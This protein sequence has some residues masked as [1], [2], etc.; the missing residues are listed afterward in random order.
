MSASGILIRSA[1]GMMNKDPQKFRKSLIPI[2][3][4]CVGLIVALLV[5]VFALS[6]GV[7]EML[8]EGAETPYAVIEAYDKWYGAITIAVISGMVIMAVC[9]AAAII[10]GRK[11]AAAVA[12][13][14]F[15][16]AIGFFILGVM[17]VSEEIPALR[18]KA[19]EDMAQITEGRLESA[20]RCFK[21]PYRGSGRAGLPG[22]YTEGQPTMFTVYEGRGEKDKWRDYYFLGSLGFVLD[23]DR[24]YDED[25]SSLWNEEN[26]GWYFVTYTT[27]FGVVISA[28]P[29]N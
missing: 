5:L 27:N 12:C 25:K 26:V 14:I 7:L 9:S 2:I 15:V 17:Y 10:I 22:P 21:R 1:V 3:V 23:A 29:L 6:P 13:A 18:T 4:S 16:S 8:L 24:M 28:E 11:S 20:K 19:R